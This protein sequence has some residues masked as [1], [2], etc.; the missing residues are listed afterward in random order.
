M[1]AWTWEEWLILVCGAGAV[2]LAQ[3]SLQPYA[4]FAGLA[5]QVG[6][7]RRIDRKTNPGMWLT[8]AVYA[9]VWLWGLWRFWL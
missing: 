4:C 7:F 5:G 8:S 1:T 6:W 3:T 2:A 9:G